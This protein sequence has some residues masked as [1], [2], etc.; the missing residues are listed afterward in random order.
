MRTKSKQISPSILATNNPHDA[1]VS[2]PGSPTN[3]PKDTRPPHLVQRLHL[4]VLKERRQQLDGMVSQYHREDP[5]SLMPMQI[6]EAQP[7]KP[8]T[9][10]HNLKNGH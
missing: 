6:T 1:V 2:T 5:K 10:N 3:H 8:L 9:M 7:L 4:Q